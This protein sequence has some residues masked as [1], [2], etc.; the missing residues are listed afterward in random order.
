MKSIRH[1]EQPPGIQLCSVGGFAE[2]QLQKMNCHFWTLESHM[3][4]VVQVAKTMNKK[5]VYLSPD[6]PEPL[7]SVD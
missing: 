2:K 3:E 7:E 5:L 1:L 4:D 6:A